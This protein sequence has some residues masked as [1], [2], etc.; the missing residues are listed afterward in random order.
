MTELERNILEILQN[1]SRTP[2]EQVAVMA[3]CSVEEAKKTITKLE[4]ERIILKYTTVIDSDRVYDNG[5]VQALIEVRI[6]PQRDLGF[7]AVAERIYG[8]ED[9]QAVYLMS[10]D[11]DLAVLMHGRSM[12]QV[13]QFVSEKLSTIEGVLSTATHFVLKK[14]KDQG[15]AFKSDSEDSRL[16]VS[17]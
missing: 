7:D 16:V 4:S 15:V 14:Y 12:R 3:G 5:Y 8:Y 17:P 6:T 9:V 1:D 10:G 13:A 2:L 11:Y